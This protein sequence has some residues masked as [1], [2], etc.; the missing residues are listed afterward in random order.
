M[1]QLLKVSAGELRRGMEYKIVYKGRP[2]GDPMRMSGKTLR[3]RNITRS[4]VAIFPYSLNFVED[5]DPNA[6]YSIPLYDGIDQQFDYNRV[7]M[8]WDFFQTYTGPMAAG[9]GPESGL[10]PE[11]RRAAA[12]AQPAPAQPAPAQPAPA[13]APAPR[14]AARNPNA[15]VGGRRRRQAKRATR[16]SR[17]R[18]SRKSRKARR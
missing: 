4:G 16:K 2:G 6:R 8:N 12:A 15:P 11:N 14:P 13:A 3:F 10:M 17:R 5:S 18:G 9:Y 1:S 7:N